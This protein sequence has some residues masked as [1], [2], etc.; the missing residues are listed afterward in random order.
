[1]TVLAL[2]SAATLLVASPVPS[3]QV[4]AQAAPVARIAYGDL[5][6]ASAPG[7][8]ALDGRIGKAAT[9]TC[10]AMLGR[11]I[12]GLSECQAAFRDEALGNLPIA[13]LEDYAQARARRLDL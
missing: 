8:D 10:R 6:L 5:N 13:A 3:T 9:R 7:A 11:S 1:M 4:S 12:A 2:I